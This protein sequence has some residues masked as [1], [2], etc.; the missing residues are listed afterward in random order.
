VNQ[1]A[2]QGR[3]Q[4]ALYKVARGKVPSRDWP[5]RSGYLF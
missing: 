2:C 5:G 3:R 1:Y 4:H